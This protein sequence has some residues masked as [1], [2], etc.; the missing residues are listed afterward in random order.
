MANILTAAEGADIASASS[1]D[2][3]LLMVLSQVDSTIQQATGRDWTK[4][5]PVHPIAKRAAM[6][7]LAIDYDLGTLTP[8]QNAVL[9]RAYTSALAQLET[10][11]VGLSALDNV[12]AAR[13]A[14]DMVIYLASDALGLNLLDYNRL[15][16]GYQ[17][18]VAQAVLDG[19][20]SDGY[21]DTDALQAVLDT[22][23]EA[24][25]T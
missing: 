2:A 16:P 12:N 15:L 23:V 11:A 22:A 21:A 18:S 6:C 9:E 4:D 13:S 8:Q 1:T 3:R 10:L 19:R 7:R 17:Q 5:S 20:P 14:R 25:T 24:V